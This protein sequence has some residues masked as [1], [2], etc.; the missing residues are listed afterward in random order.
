M[1]TPYPLWMQPPTL[2]PAARHV[3]RQQPNQEHLTWP[4]KLPIK[5][6]VGFEL[7]DILH[8]VPGQGCQL[9]KYV[10]KV[11]LQAWAFQKATTSLEDIKDMVAWEAPPSGH[12]S[13]ASTFMWVVKFRVKYRNSR[14][15]V[16]RLRSR[17][18]LYGRWAIGWAFHRAF[19]CY[20]KYA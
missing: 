7:E 16:W 9:V 13:R 5:D 2:T 11:D 6:S 1:S 4:W 20:L 15:A 14:T 8:R 10:Y 12:D 19:L 18:R 3:A 17:T